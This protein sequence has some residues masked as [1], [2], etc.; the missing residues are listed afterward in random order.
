MIFKKSNG[1]PD[2]LFLKCASAKFIWLLSPGRQNRK[3]NNSYTNLLGNLINLW[4][5]LKINCLLVNYFSSL[6]YNR[7]IVQDLIFNM[8]FHSIRYGTHSIKSSDD[9]HSKVHD[10][11][12]HSLLRSLEQR[13]PRPFC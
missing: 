13:Q 9:I 2:Q 6:F 8:H 10:Y 5:M 12:I 7:Y 11:H 3:S 4:I 1:Y